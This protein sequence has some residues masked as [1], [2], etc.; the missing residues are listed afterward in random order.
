[1]VENLRVEGYPPVYVQARTCC[2][3]DDMMTFQDKVNHSLQKLEEEVLAHIFG[4]KRGEAVRN[5]TNGG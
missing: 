5:S 2:E 4:A 3:E 1:M